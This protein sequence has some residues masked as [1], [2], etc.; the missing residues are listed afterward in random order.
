MVLLA[1]AF[2]HTLYVNRSIT[3]GAFVA[4]VVIALAAFFVA[5]EKAWRKILKNEIKE[6]TKELEEYLCKLKGSEERCR[7]LVDS[8]DDLIYTIGKDCDVLTVNQ[9][10]SGLVGQRPRGH[11]RQKYK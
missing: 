3:Q 11:H 1:G 6:K 2:I 10:G 7:S 9:Y 8:A 5:N 4:S